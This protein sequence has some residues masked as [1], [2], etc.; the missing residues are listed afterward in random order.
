MNMKTT[1]KAAILATSI[2]SVGVM[3]AGVKP[4]EFSTPDFA[5][6]E[7]KMRFETEIVPE[8]GLVM[9]DQDGK[10]ALLD[11]DGNSSFDSDGVS[12][13]VYDNTNNLDYAMIKSNKINLSST[14]ATAMQTTFGDTS[15]VLP[16][17]VLLWSGTTYSDG[18]M[19]YQEWRDASAAESIKVKQGVPVT[20][21]LRTNLH[22]YQVPVDNDA[23]ISPRL[24]MNCFPE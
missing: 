2:L 8:C 10:L 23:F 16:Q 6:G 4:S 15:D 22:N 11:D 1:F 24:E 13:T 21:Q 5:A 18:E 12:F 9:H 20:L 7:Y 3:A 14:I 19:V 17:T